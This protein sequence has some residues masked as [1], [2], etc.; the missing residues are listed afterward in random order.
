MKGPSKGSRCILGTSSRKGGISS[1]ASKTTS[2]TPFSSFHPTCQRQQARARNAFSRRN[3]TRFLIE[4]KRYRTNNERLYS[5]VWG[6]CAENSRAELESSDDFEDVSRK[7]DG[8]GLLRILRSVMQNYQDKKYGPLASFQV[9]RQ[10][11]GYRQHENQSTR[12][13]YEGFK[14]MARVLETIQATV[15]PDPGTVKLVAKAG[16]S[17]SV[18]AANA[19]ECEL[20]V[21][22]LC[23]AHEKRF[24]GM[25]NSLENQFLMGQDNYPKT[26]ME[27]YSLMA[28]WKENRVGVSGGN[29]G[30]ACTHIGG[31]EKTLDS[32]EGTTL[33][34]TGKGRRSGFDKSK[35][36]CHSCNQKGH[37]QWEPVF[38]NPQPG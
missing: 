18:T 2:P 3:A 11:F 30:V 12:D 5:V 31:A 22:F 23:G 25:L 17:V 6:Q 24:Q 26:L 1:R 34:T 10:F 33:T 15:G 13:Y 7:L 27:A 16:D 29:D 28:G 19:K 38:L 21:A 20:A 9:K 8:L 35:V 4:K 37:F 14:S 36:L 32:D